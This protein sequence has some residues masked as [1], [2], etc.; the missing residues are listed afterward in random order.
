MHTITQSGI[1]NF[2]ASVPPTQ[3]LSAASFAR[4]SNHVAEL[5][6]LAI[7]EIIKCFVEVLCGLCR[8]SVLENSARRLEAILAHQPESEGE[9]GEGLAAVESL[10]NG[11]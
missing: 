2:A 8:L 10:I 5:V 4:P 1:E 7:R 6:V 3:V 9:E 11:E